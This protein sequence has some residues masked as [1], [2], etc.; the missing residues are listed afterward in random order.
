MPSPVGG[1]LERLAQEFPADRAAWRNLGRTLYLDRKYEEALA[2][3]DRVVRIEPEDRI[4]H[5]HRMLILRALGGRARGG[6]RGGG[7]RVLR[8][9]RVGARDHAPVP[10]WRTPE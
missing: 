8:N 6:D 9:R 4:A 7:L 2:P 10:G 1:G 3:F 5:Y